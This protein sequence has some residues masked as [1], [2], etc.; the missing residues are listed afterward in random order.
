M[1]SPTRK[2]ARTQ[3][4]TFSQSDEQPGEAE[5]SPSGNQKLTLQR[6]LKKRESDRKCQRISRERTKSRITY[7]EGLVEKLSHADDSGKVASLLTLVSQLQEER[8]ALATKIKN[9]EGILFP[10]SGLSTESAPSMIDAAIPTQ[11]AV[12]TESGSSLQSASVSV[13][14]AS[15][16]PALEQTSLETFKHP[17]VPSVA[18]QAIMPARSTNDFGNLPNSRLA[19]ASI[20]FGLGSPRYMPLMPSVRSGMCE[21]RY[22][23]S[24]KN[25]NLNYWYQGNT[26]LSAWM[27]WPTLVPP[28]PEDDPFHDDTPIRAIVEGWDAVEQRGHVHPMWRLMRTMDEHLFVHAQTPKDRLSILYNVSRVLSAHIDPTKKQYAHL[29]TYWLSR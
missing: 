3:S 15:A 5:D 12:L 29:P 23:R 13:K 21:C 7:L 27:K 18:S 6:R 8:D 20:Q 28:V 9:I 2:K 11:S 25:Q 1:T 4:E 17:R 24:L 10:G 14:A 26:T 16:T 22:A 19:Q